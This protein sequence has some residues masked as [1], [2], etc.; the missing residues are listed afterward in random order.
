MAPPD[1][2]EYSYLFLLL[3]IKRLV[4]RLAFIACFIFQSSRHYCGGEGNTI[5]Q[6]SCHYCFIFQFSTRLAIIRLI[7]LLI[8]KN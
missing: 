7:I 5:F 4:N 1:E 8:Q 6:L 2:V 3:A